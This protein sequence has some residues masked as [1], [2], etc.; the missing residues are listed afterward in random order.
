MK[1]IYTFDDVALFNS[2]SSGEQDKT[3]EVE[4]SEWIAPI[5]TSRN[6]FTISMQLEVIQTS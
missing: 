6:P 2:F 1:K 3:S 4:Q 5:E